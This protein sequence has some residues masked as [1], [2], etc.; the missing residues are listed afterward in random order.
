VGRTRLDP[1]NGN[2]HDGAAA[3]APEAGGPNAAD[4][5]AERRASV[6]DTGGASVVDAV[7]DVRVGTPDTGGPNAVDTVADGRAGSPD[8]GGANVVDGVAD[9]R[10]GSPDTG[11]PEVVDA[12]ADGK[13]GSPDT[14]RPDGVDAAADGRTDARETGDADAVDAGAEAGDV[15]T[16]SVDSGSDAPASGPYLLTVTI[17]GGGVGTVTSSP[18]G[19][20]CVPTC[21]AA[22]AASPVK[23]SART[24]NGSDSRFAG[25]GGACAGLTR[26]CT[27]ALTSSA[28]VTARFEPIDHN[29]VFLSSVNT[30]T[31]DL[32]SAVAYDGQ[33]NQLA[34]AA[35]INN[36]AGNAYIAWVSD[37]QGSALSRLGTA[38][39]FMRM[40]GEPVADDP[41]AMIAHAQFYNPINIDEKGTAPFGYRVVLTGMDPDGNG[42]Q[43]DCNDWTAKSGTATGTAGCDNCGPPT[44]YYWENASCGD[45]V[46]SVYCFMK[47]KTA[48]L[49]ISPQVGRRVFLTNGP[50]KIGQSADAQ[51]ESAKPSGTGPVAALRATTTTAASTMID[52]TA[53]YVRPDGVVVGLGADLIAGTLKSGIWQQGNGQYQDNIA[54]WSGSN[55]PSE[56]GTSA[57][58]C[59][60]WTQ[61]T[62]AALTG[63]SAATDPAWWL[64]A[65]PWTCA[66]TYTW[67]YCIEK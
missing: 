51:C 28:T 34:T 52:P 17:F 44:W 15:D 27:V 57:G 19:I 12:G 3:S 10:A 25:W 41:A 40:D 9:V 55:S 58:T 53:T 37:S 63:A 6:P 5:P 26:D 64:N 60:D 16:G 1:S 56:L 35:G 47:T 43:T 65:Q 54:V 8:I 31:P 14:G 59:S 18:A 39:G 48:A 38:R 61:N 29:L 62:G 2:P 46:G 30:Y 66:N 21:S 4:A 36:A 22:F 11:G 7:A 49:T 13:A 24:T 33:C 42:T 32:G 20:Q 45:L 23:L 50:V 67:F